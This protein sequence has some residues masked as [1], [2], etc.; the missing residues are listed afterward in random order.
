MSATL[1][2]QPHT[3]FSS[4][5]DRTA[6]EPPELRGLGRDGVRLMIATPAGI[7]HTVFSHLAEHLRSGDVL[8]VNTSATVARPAGRQ[9]GRIGR[10][11]AYR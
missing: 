7:G 3:R 8:I 2:S 1:V 4:P 6:T 5:E 9:P 11:G 10:R